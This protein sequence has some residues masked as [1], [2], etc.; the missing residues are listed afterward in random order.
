[1]IKSFFFYLSLLDLTYIYCIPCPILHWDYLKPLKSSIPY[2]TPHHIFHYVLSSVFLY[3]MSVCSILQISLLIYYSILLPLLYYANLLSAVLFSAFSHMV[4]LIQFH[5]PL[6]FSTLGLQYSFGLALNYPVLTLPY[7][8]VIRLS[9]SYP[10]FLF[11]LGHHDNVG[12]VLLPD[13]PPEFP[14][15]LREGSLSGDVGILTAV[16]INIV[17]VDIVTAWDTCMIRETWKL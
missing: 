16:A 6:P 17:S 13:H 12:C 5:P 1:M 10:W 4:D 3:R 2:G 9:W 7:S 14:K 15:S 11:Q 8:D